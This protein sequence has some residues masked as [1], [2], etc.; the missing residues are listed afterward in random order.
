M[1]VSGGRMLATWMDRG[2]REVGRSG[3]RVDVC[4][5]CLG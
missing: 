2:Y 1:M 4:R 5:N 3:V